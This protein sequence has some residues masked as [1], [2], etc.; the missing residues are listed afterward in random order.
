MSGGLS[1]YI[2]VFLIFL[3]CYNDFGFVGQGQRFLAFPIEGV[4]FYS[5]QACIILFF[6]SLVLGGVTEDCDIALCDSA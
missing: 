6:I 4:F 5:G 2:V 1:F 3:T